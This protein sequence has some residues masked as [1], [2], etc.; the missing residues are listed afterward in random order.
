RVDIRLDSGGHDAVPPAGSDSGHAAAGGADTRPAARR[1]ATRRFYRSEAAW[2]WWRDAVAGGGAGRPERDGTLRWSY[3][4]QPDR[5][6]GA[7]RRR[8]RR[9]WS[10]WFWQVHPVQRDHGSGRGGG[11]LYPLLRRR[12]HGACGLPDP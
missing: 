8:G 3:R 10:E 7:E 12:N 2:S 4:A 6:E 5:V 1:C 9:D 11:G